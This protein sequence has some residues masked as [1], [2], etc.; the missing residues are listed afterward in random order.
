MKKILP[1]KVKEKRLFR[2]ATSLK[3]KKMLHDNPRLRNNQTG[4]R[5]G[6][7]NIWIDSCVG[8][9]LL[10]L[11]L[12][13]S[14]WLWVAFHQLFIVHEKDYIIGL[15]IH[16]CFLTGTPQGLNFLCPV[17]T[18]KFSLRWLN[19]VFTRPYL[20]FSFGHLS[21]LNLHQTLVLD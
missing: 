21:M 9:V 18:P 11:S 12:S 7:K 19:T 20:A 17:G 5:I 13:V 3:K 2:H 16:S 1:Q 6:R 15:F 14:I 8:R 10:E 4:Q